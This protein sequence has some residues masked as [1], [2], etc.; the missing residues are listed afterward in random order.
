L[1]KPLY[2]IAKYSYNKNTITKHNNPTNQSKKMKGTEKQ[3]AYAL[4]II[5]D[6]TNKMHRSIDNLER[7]YE[8]ES[9]EWLQRIIELKKLLKQAVE[10][11]LNG[12][13]YAG[14]IIENKLFLSCPRSIVRSLWKNSALNDFKK[15]AKEYREAGMPLDHLTSV[16]E[17]WN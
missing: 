1:Q 8:G 3:L 9:E 16:I 13:D 12:F 15:L 17:N 14:N 5:A 6:T 11:H 7:R 2:I 4:K 10:L